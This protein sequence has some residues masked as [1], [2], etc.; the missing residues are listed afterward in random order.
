MKLKILLALLFAKKFML[1]IGDKEKKII[2]N[3]D[4]KEVCKSGNAIYL[5]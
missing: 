3:Y 2:T 1:I 5:K 4:Q